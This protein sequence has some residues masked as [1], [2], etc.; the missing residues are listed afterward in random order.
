MGILTECNESLEKL[1][2]FTYSAHFAN[3]FDW[4]IRLC[5]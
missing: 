3:D 5:L 1:R 2:E 4:K